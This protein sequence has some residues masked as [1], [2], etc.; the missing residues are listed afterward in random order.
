MRSGAEAVE[1]RTEIEIAAFIE[2]LSSP[3]ARRAFE[4]FLSKRS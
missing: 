1:Q 2:R 4:G 3:E